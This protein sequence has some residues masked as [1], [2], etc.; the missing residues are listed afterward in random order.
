MVGFHRLSS[1]QNTASSRWSFPDRIRLEICRRNTV[2]FHQLFSGRNTVGNKRRLAD[3]HFRPESGRK[4]VGDCGWFSPIVFQPE[5]CRKYMVPSR[6]SVPTGIWS[7]ICRRITVDCFPVGIRPEIYDD[8]SKGSFIIPRLEGRHPPE[9]LITLANHL[10][11]AKDFLRVP[12]FYP[13][14]QKIST[15]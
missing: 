11:C 15:V 5:Y 10:I 7:E 1:G 12:L 8:F 3:S 13:R 4:F 14:I 9:I 2:G 6:L